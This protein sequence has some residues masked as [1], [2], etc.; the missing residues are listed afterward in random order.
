MIFFED[1]IESGV[2]ILR[3]VTTD[4]QRHWQVKTPCAPQHLW[5]GQRV[6]YIEFG[7]LQ[8]ACTPDPRKRP[9]NKVTVGKN[10]LRCLFS[11]TNKQ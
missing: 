8:L 4:T 3:L 7:A 9:P 2:H 10:L 5:E 11:L 6:W 1:L